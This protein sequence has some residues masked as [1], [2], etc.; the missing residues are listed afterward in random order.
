MR[1]GMLDCDAPTEREKIVLIRRAAKDLLDRLDD[2]NLHEAAA[3]LALTIDAIDA[4]LARMD[5]EKTSR[6]NLPVND[7]SKE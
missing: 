2:A 3:R 5:R 7:I 4:S 6:E 1:R